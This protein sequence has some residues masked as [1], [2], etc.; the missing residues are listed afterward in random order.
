M[1][2]FWICLRRHIDTR[3]LPL[4]FVTELTINKEVKRCSNSILTAR[5]WK[6]KV[7]PLMS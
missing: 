5:V 7:T 1:R 2:L 4:I 6:E 3:I